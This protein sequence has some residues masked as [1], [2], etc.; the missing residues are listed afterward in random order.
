MSGQL[1]R[2]ILTFTREGVEIRAIYRTKADLGPNT[3]GRR[4]EVID[5]TREGLRQALVSLEGDVTMC[6]SGG[7]T[8]REDTL[9]AA[10][11]PDA[12]ETDK[13]VKGA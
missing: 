10:T 5:L 1:Q 4:Q 13:L 8:Q 11:S 6:G 9:L 2:L 3:K 7:F 12:L